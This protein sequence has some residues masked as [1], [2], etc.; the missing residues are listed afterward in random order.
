MRYCVHYRKEIFLLSHRLSRGTYAQALKKMK[1]LKAIVCAGP[2]SDPF[3]CE[4]LYAS[5]RSSQL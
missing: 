4:K 2:V 3:L 5:K 1:D